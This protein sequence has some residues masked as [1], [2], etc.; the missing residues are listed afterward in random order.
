MAQ[1]N[2]ASR[3]LFK[4]DLGEQEPYWIEVLPARGMSEAVEFL[5]KPYNSRTHYAA[6]FES[7][8]MREDLKEMADSLRE[9]DGTPPS[10]EELAK[11]A[12]SS[13]WMLGEQRFDLV[14][15]LARRV[16]MDWRGVGRW[17]SDDPLP[18]SVPHLEL[19]LTSVPEAAE[20]FSIRYNERGKALAQEK[21]VSESSPNGSV[22]QEQNTASGVEIEEIP[23][24]TTESEPPVSVPT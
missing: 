2:G 18:F 10:Q 8:A 5:V 21:K 17:D 7:L 16:V 4:L 11:V 24:P 9:E 23:A 6:T 12:R 1:G 3:G 14:L 22:D 13:A 15:S 20:N 19:L